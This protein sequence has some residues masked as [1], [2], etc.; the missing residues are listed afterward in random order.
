MA[1]KNTELT[2]SLSQNYADE[3]IIENSNNK[4]PLAIS[5]AAKGQQSNM[6]SIQSSIWLQLAKHLLHPYKGIIILL[7]TYQV[8]Y[9]IA[10][11][12]MYMKTSLSFDLLL[13]K[14]SPS[15]MAYHDLEQKFSGKF[16]TLWEE[17]VMVA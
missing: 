5:S 14:K 4:T 12:A 16:I 6:L 15:L 8:L 11:H 9:P 10:E 17:V 7:L 2:T 1:E 3:A 13:P